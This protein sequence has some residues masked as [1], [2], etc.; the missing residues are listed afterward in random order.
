[1]CLFSISLLILTV[2]TTVLQGVLVEDTYKRL[3]SN[4]SS[5]HTFDTKSASSLVDCA[6]FCTQSSVCKSFAWKKDKCGLMD[7]CPLYCSPATEGKDGWN[8]YSTK[9]RLQSENYEL[10]S[11]VLFLIILP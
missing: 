2:T 10:R 8:V 4:C 11:T 3:W 6:L 7:I 5:V 9:G 1:M